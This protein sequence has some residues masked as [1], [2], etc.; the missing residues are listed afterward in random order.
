[1]QITNQRQLDDCAT[2]AVGGGVLVRVLALILLGG[3]AHTSAADD[4]ESTAA[5]YSGPRARPSAKE[6]IEL[7]PGPHLFLDEFLIASSSN[8]T[9]EVNVPARDP[10]IPNPLVTGREDGCFQP[11]LSVIWDAQS[12]RFR[13]PL[14]Q[15]EAAALTLNLEATAGSVTVQIL[16]AKDRPVRGFTQQDCPPVSGDGLAVPVRWKQSLTTLEGKPVRLEFFLQNSRL[17]AFELVGSL[18]KP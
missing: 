14:V 5:I 1:M 9:R 16:D 2:G 10:A 11:Y 4:A 18:E 17:F 13:T 15:F 6:P 3:T 7:Q 12:G 8:I